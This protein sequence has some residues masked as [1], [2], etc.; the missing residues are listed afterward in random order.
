MFTTLTETLGAAKDTFMGAVL[1]RF[2]ADERDVRVQGYEGGKEPVA[3]DI[4]MRTANLEFHHELNTP[5][6]HEETLHTSL[7]T[8]QT[9][10]STQGNR[11]S[12]NA[13]RA[14]GL[15]P[16]RVTATE[17]RDA[18]IERING[19]EVYG[20]FTRQAATQTGQQT[21]A[22]PVPNVRGGDGASLMGDLSQ[23]DAYSAPSNYWAN[24]VGGRG[25]A[26][27]RMRDKDAELGIQTKNKTGWVQIAHN[28]PAQ[29]MQRT[30]SA[31]TTMAL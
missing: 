13:G 3:T 26:M 1:G 10:H 25:N 8:N 6:A 29:T 24:A 27:E 16:D 31:P 7:S 18:P 15:S 11:D 4:G 14:A 30:R 12:G 20:E 23:M 22:I 21:V 9:D 5:F 17:G 19:K 2:D 28:P